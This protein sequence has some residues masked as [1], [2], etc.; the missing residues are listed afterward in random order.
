MIFF[1]RFDASGASSSSSP[2]ARAGEALN[3][4]VEGGLYK[5]RTKLFCRHLLISYEKTSSFL[6]ST[7]M[8]GNWPCNTSTEIDLSTK[9][10][11]YPNKKWLIILVNQGEI[12][13]MLCSIR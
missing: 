11:E 1:S 3:V 2:T 12:T 4:G 7:Y 9:T 8:Y 10:E 6:L 13:G 5:K